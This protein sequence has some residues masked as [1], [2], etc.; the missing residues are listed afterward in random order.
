[1]AYTPGGFPYDGSSLPGGKTPGQNVSITEWNDHISRLTNAANA[2]LAGDY[3]GAADMSGGMPDAAPTG[4][5]RWT[6][7]G[8]EAKWSRNGRGYRQLFHDRS[9]EEFGVVFDSHSDANLLANTAALQDALDWGFDEVDHQRFPRLVFPPRYLAIADTVA[10]RGTQAGALAIVC[11]IEG[12]VPFNS[13]KATLAWYGDPDKTILY[14]E[15]MNRGLLRDIEVDGRSVAGHPLHIAAS[16]FADPTVLAATTGVRVVRCRFKHVRPGVVGN[17]CIAL[18]TD[19]ALVSGATYQ[20]SEF[21]FS[22]VDCIPEDSG[23][24]GFDV[25]NIKGYGIKNL[26]GGNCKNGTLD[27]CTF[28]TANVALDLITDSGAWFAL[29]CQFGNVR[30]GI[31]HNDSQLC[32]INGDMECNF[33]AAQFLSGG[34]TGA[35][36]VRLIGLQCAVGAGAGADLINYGGQLSVENSFFFNGGDSFWLKVGASPSGSGSIRSF[37]NIFRLCG[38]DASLPRAPFRDGSNND[39]APES[40]YGAENGLG[41]SSWGDVD[42][43]GGGAPLIL[44]AFDSKPKTLFSLA[45]NGPFQPKFLAI[46][47][48][49]TLGNATVVALD[50]T[51]GSLTATLPSAA[52][53]NKGREHTVYKSDS[54][55]NTVTCNGVVLSKQWEYVRVKSTGAAWVTTDRPASST[56]PGYL[57]TGAQVIGGPKSLTDPLTYIGASG[58]TAHAG[59]GQGSATAI[60]AEVSIVATAASSGDSIKLPTAALGKRAVVFNTGA[61]AVDVFPASGGA[62][63]AGS[64]DAAY[65]LSAGASREFWGVSA[66]AWRSR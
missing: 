33:G 47:S 1:M 52:A 11:S 39:L 51:S 23:G 46:G 42:D 2:Q 59:G 3:H 64:T 45:L 7:D 61:S 50:A 55:G 13:I 24:P 15:S 37:Q 5:S 9:I 36:A 28:G 44:Q 8:G 29:N 56:L 16:T 4:Q 43:L 38:R 49:I 27:H 17:G 22:E 53:A 14:F 31:R 26:S 54:G 48:N 41:I 58:L 19:P 18:G 40:G 63:D 62:I 66:T 10:A 21:L 30:T 34:G 65:S 20:A 32:V 57:T 60:T 25:A 12:G 6:S 35:G